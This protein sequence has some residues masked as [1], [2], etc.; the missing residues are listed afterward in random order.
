MNKI[1]NSTDNVFSMLPHWNNGKIHFT[2]DYG[3]NWLYNP[4]KRLNRL[5]D[6]KTKQVEG[7]INALET[8]TH[9]VAHWIDIILRGKTERLFKKDYGMSFNTARSKKISFQSLKIE[10]K[11]IAI[12]LKLFRMMGFSWEDIERVAD[13]LYSS[14]G[15]I[16]HF[17]AVTQEQWEMFSGEQL[18]KEARALRAPVIEQAMRKFLDLFN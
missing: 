17:H 14:L 12:E 16:D 13:D 6:I 4:R 2:S 9:E 7:P 15:N 18:V 5:L 10:L 11:V 3:S 1:I 8:T